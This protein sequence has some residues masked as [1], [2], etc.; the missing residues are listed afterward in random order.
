MGVWTTTSMQEAFGPYPGDEFMWVLEGQ[1]SMVDGDG[2]E[3][4]V[5]QGE[6]FCVRNAIPISWKQVGFLRKFYMTYANPKESTPEITSAEGGVRLLDAAEL[7]PGMTRM[8]NTEPLVIV[9]EAPLQHDN[10]MFTNDAGNMFVGMWDSTPFDS[11]MRPFPWHE[12]VQLLEGEVTISEASGEIHLFSAG[13]AFFI[14][15]GTVCRWQ[16]SG[17][18]KKYYSIL[19]SG[20][21]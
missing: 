20:A 15:M 5:K 14:P 8:D 21:D 4:L 13:D 1:V 19:E 18:L 2:G 16:N 9:G 11:E 7:A 12:M 6:T 3:T 10:V 17:Y